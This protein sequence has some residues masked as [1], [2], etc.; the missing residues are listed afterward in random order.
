M[1]VRTHVMIPSP[2]RPDIQSEDDIRTI[3]DTFYSE[4]ETDPV[5]GRH[6]AA[7]DMAAHLPKMYAFWSTVVFHTGAYRGRPFDAHVHFPIPLEA[8][9]FAQWL[10]RF[11]ATIDARFAGEAAQR[12]KQKARQIATMFQIRLGIE[13]DLLPLLDEEER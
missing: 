1:P 11:E 13:P 12:M 8:R 5:I 6:F 10:G 2:D 7:T 9:H 3:V 4:I